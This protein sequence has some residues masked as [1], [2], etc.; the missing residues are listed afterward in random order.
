VVIPQLLMILFCLSTGH[1][2]AS[3]RGTRH[4]ETWNFRAELRLFASA[5][6]LAPKAETVLT[7][8]SCLGLRARGRYSPAEAH[9]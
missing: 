5:A 1:L 4:V 6:V 3:S 2:A 9:F 8:P 7:Q